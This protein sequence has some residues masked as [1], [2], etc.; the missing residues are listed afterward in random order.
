MP[1]SHRADEESRMRAREQERA[2]HIC[3]MASPEHRDLKNL[4]DRQ[5]RERQKQD[6]SAGYVARRPP[7][8]VVAERDRVYAA[9]DPITA[10]LGDPPPGRRAIDHRENR[11]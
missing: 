9:L 3:R 1:S 4:R 5:R 8:E 2:R 10:L 11:T 7:P 6:A